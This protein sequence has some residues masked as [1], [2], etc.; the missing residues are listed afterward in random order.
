MTYKAQVCVCAD[1]PVTLSLKGNVAIHFLLLTAIAVSQTRCMYAPSHWFIT[2][3]VNA[4]S[5]FLKGSLSF[6]ILNTFL[7]VCNNGKSHKI[8]FFYSKKC[9][10]YI[11]YIYSAS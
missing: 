8:F 1:I 11:L 10:I 5:L 9:C 6:C 7:C 2:V 4:S 3:E